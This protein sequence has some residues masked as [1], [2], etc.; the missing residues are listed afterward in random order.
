MRASA[1]RLTLRK[2]GRGAGQVGEDGGG[3]SRPVTGGARRATAAV[4]ES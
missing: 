4:G 3:V 1:H 2:A